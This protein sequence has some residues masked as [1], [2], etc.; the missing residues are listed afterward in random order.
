[1][2]IELGQV[3]YNCKNTYTTPL[4]S[5]DKKLDLT[6][7]FRADGS[8]I[9]NLINA[10]N[11]EKNSPEDK[12]IFLLD[13]YEN[14]EGY[15]VTKGVEN[16]YSY[17]GIQ[18]DQPLYVNMEIS[19]AR[20]LIRWGEV[21]RSG[22]GKYENKNL[23][24]Q[25]LD[26]ASKLATRKLDSVDIIRDGSDISIFSLEEPFLSGFKAN[27][28]YPLELSLFLTLNRNFHGLISYLHNGTKMYGWLKKGSTSP[29]DTN[30]NWELWLKSTN[31]ETSDNLILS[32]REDL[33]FELREDG[34]Y[35]LQETY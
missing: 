7:K 31:I 8:G 30:F 1:M 17:S 35:C 5:F 26:S 14:E 33:G 15:I 4:K 22:L 34:G 11:L 21:I 27:F 25:V 20:N 3:E 29:I 19:P 2:P 10:T 23:K 9:L 24:I 32:L 16:L 6:S 18:N 13:C 28:N 12:D